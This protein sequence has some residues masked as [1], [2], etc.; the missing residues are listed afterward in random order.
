MKVLFL[1]DYREANPYQRELADALRARGIVVTADPTRRR[2]IFP[3]LEAIRRHGRPHIVHVHWKEPYIS[4]ARTDVSRVR[5][6]RTLAELRLVRAAGMGVVWTAHDLWRHDRPLEPLE[7]DFTRSLVRVSGAVIAHCEAARAELVETLQL[8]A[9]EA[10]KVRVIA[11][12]HYRDSYDDRITRPD[13]RR[14]LGV[15]ADAFVITFLG[16][17]RPYK[18]V[19]ELIEAFSELDEPRA[20]LLIAGRSETDAFAADVERAAARDPRI[21]TRM[22]FLPD[23]ELQVY[24]NAA[25][26]V[27]FPFRAIFTSASVLLAMSFGRAVIA[28]RRGCIAETVDEAGAILYDPVDADG[29]RI[30]LRRSMSA[31]LEAMGAHNR[32]RCAEFDW[33]RIADATLDVYRAVI[34]RPGR[35]VGA[36]G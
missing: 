18:G 17:V 3:V 12:G 25:D 1:P 22:G 19:L 26:V 10:A 4:G 13:A 24:L 33:G 34:R 6:I 32:A 9:P 14:R 27:A 30:A 8:E 5:V 35:G 29:L 36:G 16:W 7:A 20:R 2:R 15:P 11:Q 21:A 28:P 23:D 31:D